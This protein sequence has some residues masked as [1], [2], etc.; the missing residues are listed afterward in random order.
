MSLGASLVSGED[1]SDGAI[2]SKR[3][4]E[5]D[6]AVENT[7]GRRPTHSANDSDGG[8]ESDYSDESFDEDEVY[9][10]DFDDFE[11]GN[12]SPEGDATGDLCVVTYA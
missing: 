3:V 10:D 1:G 11:E 12:P 5:Q 7:D 6:F 4:V 2:A 9:D 8:D